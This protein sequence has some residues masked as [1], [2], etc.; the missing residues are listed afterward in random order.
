MF[1]VFANTLFEWLDPIIAIEKACLYE[2]NGVANTFYFRH[3]R[4]TA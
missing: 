3:T 4:T 2:F 1:I